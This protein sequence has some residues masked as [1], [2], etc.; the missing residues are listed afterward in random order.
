MGIRVGING[1]GRIGRLARA[2]GAAHV[3]VAGDV[4]DVAAPSDRTLRQPV[5]RMRQFPEL[6]WHLIPGNHDPNLPG[7]LWD[8]LRRAG[9]PDN[10][11]AHLQPEPVPLGPDEAPFPRPRSR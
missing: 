8:R 11:H 2:E 10:V 7:G 1:F 5:E 4:W 9:L 6:R 3:L